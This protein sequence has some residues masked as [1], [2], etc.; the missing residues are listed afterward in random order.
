MKTIV[1]RTRRPLK[2]QLHGGKV[3]HLGPGKTGQIADPNVER[4]SFKKLV[5]AGDVEVL[6]EGDS[7]GPQAASSGS[8]GETSQGHQPTMGVRP[9]GNR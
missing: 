7:A 2:I 4:D 3:L 5:E 9:K 8:A 1:N 6:G